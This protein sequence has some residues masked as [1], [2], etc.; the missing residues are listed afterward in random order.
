MQIHFG[1]RKMNQFQK[2][3]RISHLKKHS[4]KLGINVDTSYICIIMYSLILIL[5]FIGEICI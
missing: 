4:L 5:Y 1:Y 2:S 3:A